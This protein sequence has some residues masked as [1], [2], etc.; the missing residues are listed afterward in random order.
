MAV[1]VAPHRFTVDDYHAM[2]RAGVLRDDDRVELIE[3]E[4]VDMTP[5]GS[6]HAAVVDL[7]TR[8]LVMGCGTR[9]I[10]RVQGPVRLGAHSEPQPDLLVLEPRDDFYQRKPPTGDDVLLLIEVADSSLQYD[11]AVKLPLYARAGVREVWLVDLVRDE[12]NVKQVELSEEMEIRLRVVQLL[13]GLIKAEY[14]GSL[15]SEY[16]VNFDLSDLT[17]GI[18]VLMLEAGGEQ[19]MVRFV[20]Q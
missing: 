1:R 17:Q 5:I 19:R 4:I 10:V 20:K 8:W 12:V 16:L 2:A 7:L 11:Q 18:Y 6:R 3:G 13:Q 9:A 14:T 15:E